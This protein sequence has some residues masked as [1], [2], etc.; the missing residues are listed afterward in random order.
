MS[1]T[2]VLPRSFISVGTGLHRPECVVATDAGDVVVSDWRGGVS[3]VS[4]A[5]VVTSCLARESDVAL[6]P[7]GVAFTPDGRF[8][9]SHLGE[10]GGVWQL[11]RRGTLT[12]FLLEVEGVPLPPTNFAVTD[13]QRRT[14]ISVSTRH[15]PRQLAWR[16]GVAD[17]FVIC[18]DHRGAR[19]VADGLHY[20]N[21][22]R[23][24]PMG[25][26]LYV[27]ETFGRRL[28]RFPI[29][30]DNTLGR[31]EVVIQ[32][33]YGYLPDGFAFDE[34][35]DI[36]ITSLVSNRVIRVAAQG[37]VDVVL[38][39]MNTEFVDTTERAFAAGTM[40]AGHLGRIPQTQL[41]HV[42]SIS[43]GGRDRRTAFI[44]SLHGE[45]VYRFAAEVAGIPAPY[46][47]DFFRDAG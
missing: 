1:I 41:Q 12:P 31:S 37:A 45:C 19:I 47:S 33:G 14:W 6:R 20:T 27:I 28:I 29:A 4:P 16:P 17:G 8:L 46:S 43:F 35:G 30:S 34:M 39:D 18:C 2:A 9:L 13:A 40:S 24:D 26:W 11:D 36:W 22:V 44:G 15:R 25:R 3:C 32:L 42:T 23:V 38:Q 21:E 5:G 10:T 7:N